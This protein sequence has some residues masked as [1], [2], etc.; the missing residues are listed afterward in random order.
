MKPVC[1]SKTGYFMVGTWTDN[2]GGQPDWWIS[3]PKLLKGTEA[4]SSGALSTW[5]CCSYISKHSLLVCGWP[6]VP[7]CCGLE[8]NAPQNL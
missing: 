3:G 8:I 6:Q 7:L 4:I 1:L 5:P 2:F